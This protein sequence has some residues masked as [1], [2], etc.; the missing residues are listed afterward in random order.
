VVRNGDYTEEVDVFTDNLTIIAE[1][2]GQARV[3]GGFGFVGV[4][5]GTLRGFDITG[6][7]FVEGC[8]KVE[9]KENEVKEGFGIILFESVNCEVKNNNVHE[10]F[11]GIIGPTNITILFGEKNLVRGNNTQASLV[12]ILVY[13]GVGGDETAGKNSIFDNVCTGN[14]Y[15][16]VAFLSDLN[17]LRGNIC[18]S[19]FLLGI[20]LITSDDNAVAENKAN[21]NGEVGIGLEASNNNTV[22]KNQAKDNVSCD[23]IDLGGIDNKFIDNKFG[24]FNC[25]EVKVSDQLSCG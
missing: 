18:N 15:G 1:Q 23:A 20:Y 3:T 5:K 24:S 4:T 19:N 12:G 17:T 14:L 16:L 21:E 9:V 11:G 6:G 22:R 2:N 7:I 13:G 8:S 25:P 10:S